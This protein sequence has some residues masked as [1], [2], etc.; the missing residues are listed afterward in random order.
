MK[1]NGW[2]KEEF[3]KKLKLEVYKEPLTLKESEY[4]VFLE[5]KFRIQGNYIFYR[6]KN[7]N[8]NG[9]R[10]VWRYSDYNS[11]GPIWQKLSTMNATLKKVDSLAGQGSELLE[12]GLHKLREYANL[13]Y[14]RKIRKEAC[15]RM[16]DETGH[17]LWAAVAKAQY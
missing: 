8:E 9:E 6:I 3:E 17:K 4:G 12:S 11:Y 7:V 2:N 16:V 13:G 10:V 14:P 1:K 5:S 15:F